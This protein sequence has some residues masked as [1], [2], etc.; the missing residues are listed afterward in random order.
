MQFAILVATIIAILLGSFLT[1]SQ[2]HLFFNTQSKILDH[3]ID[4]ANAGIQYSLRKEH[5]LL[6]SVSIENDIYT[7]MIKKT[8]WGGFLSI[9][10]TTSAKTKS[11]SKMALVGSE[12]SNPAL[13]IYLTEGML[14][15]MLVGNTVIEGDAFVSQQGIQSGI[16]A[17]HYFNGRELIK[18]N[19]NL[20]KQ[21]LPELDPILINNIK[22]YLEYVPFKSN[23]VMQRESINKNSFFEKTFFVYDENKIILT[24]TY[25]GNIII[26]SED[27]VVITSSAKLTDVVVIAPKISIEEGFTGSASFIA[28]EKIVI[29]EN[30]QLDYPSSLILI[31]TKID[32]SVAVPKGE[33]PIFIPDNSSVH[34][35]VI[36]LDERIE[37]MNNAMNLFTHISIA[38]MGIV[39]GYVYCQGNIELMG[40]VTGAIYTNLFLSRE[41]GSVFMNHIFN[42]KVLGRNIDPAFGGLPF[43]ESDK[44]IVKW[45]Y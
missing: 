11:F 42:G 20:A 8:S 31:N 44:A 37:K 7:K 30:V 28:E 35:T 21:I 40:T 15:L 41:F 22:R 10:S 5:A 36:Y 39:N 25:I 24:E 33:E 34:G 6:D 14:P 13:G 18:G 9:K 43:K 32:E 38:P 1:L 12:Y 26:K 3:V 2:T 27:E 29:A 45:L 17:G 4:S 23:E 19:I 16:I